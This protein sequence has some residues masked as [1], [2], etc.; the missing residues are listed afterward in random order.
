MIEIEVRFLSPDDAAEWLRLRVEALKLA[1]EAFSA[2]LEEYESLSLDEVKKRL[3]SD[4]DAFVVG[5]FQESR[6]IGIAGFYREKG[7]KSRHKGRVWGV[8]VTP[9]ARGAGIGARMMQALLNRGAA[10]SGVEQVLLSVA[11]TQ[12]PAIRLYR[13]LGFESF[14]RE[15]RALKIGDRYIDEEYM[16][17]DLARSPA[18]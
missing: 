18:R 6:L 2:S 15:P 1:P 12:E 13:S 11:A 9:K 3:W 7:P 16:L 17:L 8:Y 14:G 4:G 5:A 10:V